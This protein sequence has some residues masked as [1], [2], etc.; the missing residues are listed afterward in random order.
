[1]LNVK[2]KNFNVQSTELECG[3]QKLAYLLRQGECT[4]QKLEFCTRK[5][6][7]RKCKLRIC[8]TNVEAN[9]KRR[10]KKQ[11]LNFDRDKMSYQCSQR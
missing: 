3:M 9:A 6:E 2:C 8:T 11:T 4:R 5:V 1:M 10:M 7:W